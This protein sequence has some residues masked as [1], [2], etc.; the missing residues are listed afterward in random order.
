MLNKKQTSTIILFVI[1]NLVPFATLI[2]PSY[3]VASEVV[4]WE[5][6]M[7]GQNLTLASSPYPTVE[8]YNNTHV[9]AFA[10]GFLGNGGNL[11]KIS[12]NIKKI[13]APG[14]DARLQGALWGYKS[15]DY[16]PS[17]V[18]GRPGNA[19]LIEL[20]STILDSDTVTTSYVWYNFT[21]SGNT[22]LDYIPYTFGLVVLD[23]DDE[24]TY[25]TNSN[26]FWAEAVSSAGVKPYACYNYGTNTGSTL[27][28]YKPTNYFVKGYVYT[29]AQLVPT[30]TPTPA[31][32][33][34]IYHYTITPTPTYTI[35]NYITSAQLTQGTD[36]GYTGTIISNSTPYGSGTYA[37]Y[38]TPLYYNGSVMLQNA[39]DSLGLTGSLVENVTLNRTGTFSLNGQG[40]FTFTLSPQYISGSW[41]TYQGYKV[42]GTITST[43]ET[44]TSYFVAE[45]SEPNLTYVG[46][47][48]GGHLGSTWAGIAT[49]PT[50]VYLNQRSAY[51]YRGQTFVANVLSGT[52]N[53]TTYSTGLSS[54][55]S[56][57]TTGTYAQVATGNVT[58]GVFTFNFA[59]RESTITIY[60]G[61]QVYVLLND[62]RN[63]TATYYFSWRANVFGSPTASG[64]IPSD[65]SG[66]S[67]SM[68]T[69]ISFL[70]LFLLIGVPAFLLGVKAGLPG[71]IVGAILGLGIGVLAG[72]VPFW[73]IFLVG[74]GTVTALLMW[75]KNNGQG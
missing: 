29:L 35:W 24:S 37:V 49:A 58:S 21:F 27:G 54:S 60:E 32:P 4:C 67:G 38:K 17:S 63:Y 23:D 44:F 62:G 52:G 59:S 26:E 31:P 9:S 40:Q 33:T 50:E 12:L 18:S 64:L 70:V 3:A 36:Y 75:R 57:W 15:S 5:Q 16:G 20:S 25:L 11:T 1:L 51:T 7:G 68:L 10:Q 74:L 8:T 53:Y 69:I 46:S 42:N 45:A 55:S 6:L 2:Q 41:K 48:T 73:F 71:L 30:P 72:L 61:Y 65:S 28:W 14:P 66:L 56:I 39:S 43:G 13:G 47:M 34:T 19:E 22:Q